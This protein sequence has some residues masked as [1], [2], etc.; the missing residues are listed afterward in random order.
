M[1]EPR[2]PPTGTVTFLFTDVEGST[3]RWEAHPQAMQAAFARQEAILRY[4]IGANGGFAY[5]LI[6][7]AFQ[8]AFPTAGQALQAVIDAQHTLSSEKW[9]AEIGDVRVRMALHTGVTEERGDDYVGPALNRV[10]RLLSAG[11]GGQVLLTLATQQLLRDNL[12]SGMTLR[13][14][15]EHRLKDLIQPERIFQVM[16]VGLPADFPPLKTLDNRPNNLPR[17]A[18]PLIG[19]E[20]EVEA[21]QSRLMRADVHL[22]TLTGVGGIGKTR[23]ALQA[24][25]EMLEEFPDGVFFV[26]LAP[27]I[28]PALVTPT[29]AYTLGLREVGGQTIEDTLKEYLK[30]KRLLL[31][32]DNAEQV[33]DAAPEVADLLKSSSQLKALVTSRAAL[34]LSMEH[35]YAVP[36]LRVPDPKELAATGSHALEARDVVPL[37]AQYEAVELFVRRSQAVKPDF[38]IDKEN[39]RVVAEICY[40]LE[41]I[42]LAIELAAARVKALLLHALLD[43]LQ[44]RLKLLTGGA[45]DLPA[46]Q[47][48]LR[49]TI[50]WSYD[51]L[52]DADKRLFRRMSVFT[53]GRTLRAADAVCNAGGDLEIDV[54]EGVASLVDNSLMYVTEGANGEPRYLMLETIHEFAREKLDESGEGEALQRQHALYFMALAEHA[55]PE[56][57]GSQQA[58]W[59]ARLE[60]EHDNLRAA[61]RWASN[62]EQ[63]AVTQAAER[64][65]V[66]LRLAGASWRFWYMRGYLTEGREQL[67]G[68][69]HVHERLTELSQAGAARAADTNH[70]EQAVQSQVP[71]GLRA[72]RAKALNGAG[73]LAHAQG[74]YAA[75]RSLHEESLAIKRGLGDKWGIA[76]SLNNLGIIAQEQ[77]DYAAARSLYVEDLTLF[78]ELGDKRGIA[79]SLNNLGIVAQEQGDYLS[80]SSLYEES[81][82]LRREL[83]DKLGIAMSLNNLGTVAKAQG[84]YTAA[85]SLYEESLGLRRE[86]GHKGGIARALYNLGAVAKAQGEYATARSLYVESLEIRREL[87]DSHG[88]AECLESFASLAALH[89]GHTGARL[90]A[91]L[92]G[93]AEALR[94]AIGSPVPPD[95]RAEHEANVAAARALL[96]R[97]TWEGAWQQ[98]RGMNM[99]KAIEIALEER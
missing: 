10:A 33:L 97:A 54:M 4:A 88:I 32:L 50:A 6:G 38:Q 26:N 14:M 7:D 49:N 40:R 37:L 99:E 90:A 80:A 82:G 44:S 91:L 98:G 47:Q 59:L 51:L 27:I 35:E 16:A 42:P 11:H 46:R 86:L 66:V 36:P 17:Q 62:L 21:V 23:L 73:N 55:E 3:K 96:D 68:V 53:G 74:D 92:F 69:L 70:D 72:Y 71:S 63:N 30:D 52:N 95:E 13:D 2:Q 78:Q 8:A 83:G 84:Q 20:R 56:L 9:P 25:A 79:S 85:R 93:G 31:V 65:G 58:E 64:A 5:K 77:G 75:A 76:S 57:T 43:R 60:D 15:G 87:G 39:A 61:L 12:P 41:G 45:R 18:T 94:E 81:L 24:A 28:D 89:N 19:R 1:P 67:A 29:V 22:L 48:T 34:H